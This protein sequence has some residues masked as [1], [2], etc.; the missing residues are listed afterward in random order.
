MPV[1][2]DL[3]S[4]E[5]KRN[6]KKLFGTLMSRPA[7]LVS[8]GINPVYACDVYV[9]ERDPTGR[10]NQYIK[11]KNGKPTGESAMLTGLPGQP[12]QDFQLDDMLPGH[13][14]TT[15]RNVVIAADQHQ[16]LHAEV[17]A[18]VTVER[19]QSGNWMITGFSIEQ[20]GTHFLYPVDLGD[21]TIG[22]V[23]DLSVDVRLL[24]LAEIGELEPFGYLPF[25][26]SAIFQGGEFSRYV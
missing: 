20:P 13:V 26:S 19:T 14:D 4:A 12:P 18:P 23:M 1:L 5:V 2:T 10:I 15:L 8:E 21:M 25:G 22:P 24:T 9:S 16:L 3:A 6:V 11:E 17:G 7:L